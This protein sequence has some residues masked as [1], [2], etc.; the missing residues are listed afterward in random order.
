[1]RTAEVG[2]KVRGRPSSLSM[3]LQLLSDLNEGKYVPVQSPVPLRTDETHSGFLESGRSLS[4]SYS[5]H[6]RTKVT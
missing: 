3:S 6:D 4:K 1:M 2:D 5:G